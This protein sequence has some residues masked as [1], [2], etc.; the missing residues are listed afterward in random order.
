MRWFRFAP[1]VPVGDAVAPEHALP[2]PIPRP[3]IRSV[4]L[5][6][7][8]A[9]AVPALI[10]LVALGPRL[11]LAHT[12]DLITD[13]GVYIPVGRLDYQLFT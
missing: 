2:M 6:R 8:R 1:A 9:L 10:F 3:R 11:V 12:L 4:A 13:E 7:L 5:P